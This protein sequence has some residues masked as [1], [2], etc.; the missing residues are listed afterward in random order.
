[1]PL[2]LA[3][4]GIPLLSQLAPG[5]ISALKR[6]SRENKTP[7]MV[8]RADMLDSDYLLTSES[9]LSGAAS[10]DSDDPLLLSIEAY[11]AGTGQPG[12]AWLRYVSRGGSVY[13]PYL[14][15]SFWDSEEHELMSFARQTM[16]PWQSAIDA[17][18]LMLSGAA[19]AGDVADS[20]ASRVLLDSIRKVCSQLDVIGENPPTSTWD[21]LKGAARAAITETEQFAGKAAAQL[22]EEVGK[23]AGNVASGFFDQAGITSLIVAGI[24]VKIAIG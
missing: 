3:S 5:I 13:A 15:A 4:D 8:A 24:A 14:N 10:S 11:V 16:V 9:V 22:A 2:L 12:A 17:A 18:A 20:D 19:M 1:M 6:L 7:G 23:A 21:K